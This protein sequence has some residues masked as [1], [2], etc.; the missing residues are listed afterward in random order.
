MSLDTEEDARL[1]EAVLER[2]QRPH[3]SYSSAEIT[4]LAREA[5]AA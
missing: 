4:A 1:I 2:M 3:W 5:L